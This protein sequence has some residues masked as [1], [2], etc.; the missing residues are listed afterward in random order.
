MRNLEALLLSADVGS[1]KL[2]LELCKTCKLPA[3][4]LP[5]F[6]NVMLFFPD[7]DVRQAA[8]ALV[9]THGSQTLISRFQADKRNYF[10]MADSAKLWKLA[11]DLK[12]DLDLDPVLFTRY[13]VIVGDDRKPPGQWNGLN[14][15][16]LPVALRFPENGPYVF[17]SIA[18]REELT[19]SGLKGAL[20]RGIGR[21]AGVKAMRLRYLKLTSADNAEELAQLTKLEWVELLGEITPAIIPA[22]F[23]HFAQ[24]K[25][26][27]VNC[28]RDLEALTALT[29]IERLDLEY[30]PV[31]DLRPLAALRSLQFLDLRSTEVHDLSPLAEPPALERLFLG[32]TKVTD[33]EPILALPLNCLEIAG[34]ERSAKMNEQLDVLRK[35][36]P[37]MVLST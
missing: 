6:V 1:V 28:L 15:E 7:A 36:R 32:R 22:I 8:R 17:E 27:T 2:G 37:D 11:R 33:F 5:A 14:R 19:L 21:M 10:A 18:A 4:I 13:L 31:A 23:Q 29:R 3:E 30:S 24:I 9:L 20:P 26:L 34:I 35:R 12:D 25:S 16:T